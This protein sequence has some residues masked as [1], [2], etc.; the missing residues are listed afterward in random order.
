MATTVYTTVPARVIYL[1]KTSITC[2]KTEII[3]IRVSPQTKMR[4]KRFVKRIKYERNLDTV[5]EVLEFIMDYF[6]QKIRFR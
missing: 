3:V 1:G 4:W 6:S 5:E 2:M